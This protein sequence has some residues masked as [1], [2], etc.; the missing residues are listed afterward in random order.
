M[1]GLAATIVTG[2]FIAYCANAFFNWIARRQ[3]DKYMLRRAEEEYQA[4]QAKHPR[5]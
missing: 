2:V 5:A 4:R 1:T 3:A